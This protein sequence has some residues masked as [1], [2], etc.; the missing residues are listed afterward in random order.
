MCQWDI[1]DTPVQQVSI[2]RMHHLT[3][4]N[5]NQL[6]LIHALK[7]LHLLNLYEYF[8]HINYSENVM[9]LKSV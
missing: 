4:Y 5:L 9:S 2:G 8:M 1:N 3:I 6:S 7:I